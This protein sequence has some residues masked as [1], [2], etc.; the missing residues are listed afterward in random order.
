MRAIASYDA[1][2]FRRLSVRSASLARAPATAVRGALL[3]VEDQ[4]IVVLFAVGVRA[5]VVDRERLAICRHDTVHTADNFA[6][7][8]E[9]EVAGVGVDCLAGAAVG[10][11]IAGNRTVLAVVREGH[12]HGHFFAVGADHLLIERRAFGALGVHPR[13]ALRRRAAEL[14]F[15]DVELPC[16]VD[17]IGRDRSGA[18][19]QR[20]QQRESKRLALL[21]SAYSEADI[22]EGRMWVD[23]GSFPGRRRNSSSRPE[24]EIQAVRMPSRLRSFG[25]DAD[26][27]FIVPQKLV[28]QSIGRPRRRC[29][30]P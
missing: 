20:A 17:G 22:R 6:A 4:R 15:C 5:L 13:R 21:C 3:L 25:S 30:N 27:N 8:P 23:T 18:A 10:V 1:D 24:A 16:S 12:V 29:K 26:G 7:L 14:R 11:G 9:R 19:E 28:A 2:I